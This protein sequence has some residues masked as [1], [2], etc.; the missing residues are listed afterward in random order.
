[1]FV[2]CRILRYRL[3]FGLLHVAMHDILEGIAPLEKKFVIQHYVSNSIFP[4]SEL[5]SRL[6]NFNYGYSESDKPIPI[7]SNTLSDPKKS[8]RS[9]SSQMFLLLCILS[10]IGDKIN[11]MMNTGHAFCF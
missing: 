7:L 11:E 2:R 5:N 9:S 1:M 3:S 10:L 8:L 6:I 4:L